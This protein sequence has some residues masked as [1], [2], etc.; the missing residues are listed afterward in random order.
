MEARD[1]RGS[2]AVAA[3]RET[4]S[5][6]PPAAGEVPGEQRRAPCVEIRVAA[7]AHVERL[8]PPRGLEQQQRGV[9]AAALREHDLGPEQ[10][11]AGSPELVERPGL[12]GGQEPAGNIECARAEAGL[13]GRERPVGSPR[14]IAR[15][16]DRTLQEC[17]GGGL[18]AARLRPAGRE[19]QLARRRPRRARRPRQPDAMRDDPDRRRDP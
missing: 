10:V 19:L 5:R 9:A 12:R 15:Q 7:E 3:A 6:P 11:D 1:P 17:G 4:S 18:A 13:G 14:G 8:E 16:R 2:G